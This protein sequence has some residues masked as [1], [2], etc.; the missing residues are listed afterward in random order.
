MKPVPLLKIAV[1][2]PVE[3]E[4]AVADLL[5]TVFHQPVALATREETLRTEVSVFCERFADWTEA[6][7]R[8]VERGLAR[9]RESGLPVG[10]ARVRTK[11][12]PPRDWAEAWKHHFRAQEIGGVLL[13]RPSWNRR[14]PRPGQVEVVLDPGLSFGTGNHPTTGFCLAQVVAGRPGNG[15]TASMLDMGCG[16]GILGIAA[17]KLGYRPI[18]GFDYDPAAVRV[19][20]E[21]A[22]QNG[23]ARAAKF[24]R[25]D[26]TRLPA[27]TGTQ[28]DL[29]CAN[30]LA[31]LHLTQ[32]PRITGQVKPGGRLVL[33]GILAV[34]F[35]TVRRQFEACG[36]KLVA[37]KGEK[38]WRSGAFVAPP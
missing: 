9:I 21:N 28:Y 36:F 15:E 33:A 6:R 24:V 34:E 7:R 23:V 27:T 17:A 16:S 20:R 1:T 3:A 38:E 13:V 5:E 22:A 31:N 37:D 29:V 12:L 4:E 26:V 19:A 10:R 32:T 25:Q 8:R 11:T 14:R 30:L 2:V 18:L 35:P